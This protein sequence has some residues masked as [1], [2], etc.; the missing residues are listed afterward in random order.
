MTSSATYAFSQSN[1]DIVLGALGR[2]KIRPTE[3]VTE[4]L[5]QASR[6]LNM[7]LVEF[8]N[9]QPNLFSSENQVVTLVAGTATYTL[10]ARTIM[11]LIATYRTGSGTSQNDKVLWPVST[12]EYQS[13]PNKLTQAAPTVYWFDRQITPQITFYPTPNAAELVELRCVRQIQDA[14]LASGETPDTPYRALDALEAGL[15]YR[16]SRFYAPDL[17]QVRKADAAEAWAIFATQ[18]T[19]NVPVY[20]TPLIGAYRA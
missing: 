13:Y 2:I 8:A 9:K 7:L 14:N 19:E 5:R 12:V 16:L 20:I 18:D 3:I 15:A 11:I 1:S 17:E 6:Q 10:T 4:H